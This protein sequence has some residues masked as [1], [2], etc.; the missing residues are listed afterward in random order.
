MPE[1]RDITQAEAVK[2]FVSFGGIERTGKGSHRVVKMP[3]GRN[4]S[5]PAGIVKVGLLKALVR[6]A[7]LAE[8]EFLA[9]LGRKRR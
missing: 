7:N 8:D 9:A 2:A 5:V 4:L 6:T 3:N 1:F